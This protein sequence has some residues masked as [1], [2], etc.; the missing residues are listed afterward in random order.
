MDE[1]DEQEA[2]VMKQDEPELALIHYRKAQAE[3]QLAKR[4]PKWNKLYTPVIDNKNQIINEIASLQL[5]LL[6][7]N[8]V[9]SPANASLSNEKT[10]TKTG[11]L[12]SIVDLYQARS[13]SNLF[14]VSDVNGMSINDLR[15]K[16]DDL[17]SGD[18]ESSTVFQDHMDTL[19]EEDYRKFGV[20]IEECNKG[21]VCNNDQDSCSVTAGRIALYLDLEQD[22][23]LKDIHM[24]LY[25]YRPEPVKSFILGAFHRFATRVSFVID[26][27]LTNLSD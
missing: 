18:L 20:P 15:G 16:T 2:A 19:G 21:R 10:A 6:Q 14:K 12:A 27:R 13:F 9:N 17:V 7:L 25:K 4:I 24:G 3:T 11:H 23:E 22:M 1:L 26:R 5:A 8:D